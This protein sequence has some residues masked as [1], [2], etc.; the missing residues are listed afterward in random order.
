MN[1]IVSINHSPETEDK[2]S[3]Y[4]IRP[5]MTR[6]DQFSKI[7]HEKDLRAQNSKNSD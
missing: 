1:A 4:D 3:F 6:K 7:P 2:C 5:I